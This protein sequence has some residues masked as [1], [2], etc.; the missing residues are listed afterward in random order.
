[1]PTF[2]IMQQERVHCGHKACPVQIELQPRA[3][4]SNG[5]KSEDNQLLMLTR[6]LADK[7][8]S[9]FDMPSVRR[10][11]QEPL[12]TQAF[13]LQ[14]LERFNTVVAAM[15]RSLDEVKRALAGDVG[16]SAALEEL[17]ASILKGQVPSSWARLNPHSQKPLGPWMKWFERRHAQYMAWIRGGEPA[18]M[19]LAGLHSPETYLAA[20]VQEACRDRGLPLDRSSTI[21]K[22][23]RMTSPDEVKE[24]PRHGCYLTGLYLEGASWDIAAD[25]LRPQ[26]PKVLVEEMP[27]LEFIPREVGDV[28]EGYSLRTPVYVTQ[29]RRDA[30]GAG[31]VFEANL[32][33]AENPALWILQGVALFLDM[34]H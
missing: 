31:L 23:T 22:V 30:M 21:T 10:T 17:S 32:S 26:T 18:V 19:W 1:M 9:E 16:F 29:A 6:D 11:M 4:G 33:T 3:G 34:D 5:C 7:L 13:L 14:E 8:P 2:L 25:C 24:K 27:I 12:P 28:I 15:R 20:L